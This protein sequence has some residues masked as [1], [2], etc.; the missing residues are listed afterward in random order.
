[1][2]LITVGLIELNCKVVHLAGAWVGGRVVERAH[3]I[4]G[5]QN[6]TMSANVFWKREVSK[7][8]QVCIMCVC[9]YK[10]HLANA[11]ERL[12]EQNIGTKGDSPT[13][14]PPTLVLKVPLFRQN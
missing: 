14:R 2:C 9:I 1:M 10:M 11:L 8:L 7:Y 13:P 4:G 5:H 6:K 12:P 3:A